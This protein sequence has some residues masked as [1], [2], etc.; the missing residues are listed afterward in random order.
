[1]FI[2]GIKT[3]SL[4]ADTRRYPRTKDAEDITLRK[5]ARNEIHRRALRVHRE[6]N[7]KF[8]HRFSQ[9]NTEV[10]GKKLEAMIMIEGY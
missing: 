9:I 8:S 10:K 4:D 3:K 7:R 1:M 6:K 2:I 5:N